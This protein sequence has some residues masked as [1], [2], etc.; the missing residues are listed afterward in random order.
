MRIKWR[1]KYEMIKM[2]RGKEMFEIFLRA[3]VEDHWWAVSI[4]ER[5]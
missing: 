3:C 2:K 4:A 1:D 5:D